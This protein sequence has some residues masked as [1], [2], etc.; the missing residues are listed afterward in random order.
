MLEANRTITIIYES[1]PLSK[2]TR[3]CGTPTVSLSVRPPQ[4][5]WQLVIYLYAA[6]DNDMEK[7]YLLSYTGYTYRTN[8]TQK[9]YASSNGVWNLPPQELHSICVDV[10]ANTKLF[11][12][13]GLYSK[14]F[15][16]VRTDSN[17][18]L[19]VIY[20]NYTKLSIPYIK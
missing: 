17:W 1:L 13:I 12:I 9:S 10:P 7:A 11:V 20:S 14:V 19:E 4:G 8:N 15:K 6:V 16:L 18:K 5:A 3:L 2:K